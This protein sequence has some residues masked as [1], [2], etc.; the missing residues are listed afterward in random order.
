MRPLSTAQVF[1]PSWEIAAGLG[2]EAHGPA[3]LIKDVLTVLHTA[4]KPTVGFEAA[5]QMLEAADET[6]AQLNERVLHVLRTYTA[7]IVERLGE[8]KDWVQRHGLLV[9][10]TFV[11]NVGA[12]YYAE[13]QTRLARAASEP[14]TIQREMES[15]LA[16]LTEAMSQNQKQ[17]ALERD[18]RVVVRPAPLRQTPDA[19]GLILRQIYP[20]DRVRVLEIEDGWAKVDVYAYSSEKL[21]EGWISRRVLRI[22]TL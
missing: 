5:V 19:K 13:E 21:C 11:L 20:D 18:E 16:D 15:H 10:L 6:E 22:P 7:A 8:A 1:Q 2:I 4:R 12:F 14:S 3:T 9:V 17:H